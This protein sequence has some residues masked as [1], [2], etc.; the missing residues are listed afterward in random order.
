MKRPWLRLIVL[1]GACLL[2]SRAILHAMTAEDRALVDAANDRDNWRLHGRTYDNQRFSPLTQINKD[3]VGELTLIRTLHT[4]VNSSFEDTPIEVDGVL[5]IVTATNHVAAWDAV[6]GEQL[7]AWAP[8][9]L[10]YTEACCG[11]QARGVAVAYG[12]VYTALFDG[13]L[14]ALDAKTGKLV[15]ETDPAKTHPEPKQ[16]YTY[17]QA[18]QVYDGMV[19]VGTAGA[20][21]ETRGMVEAYDAQTGN[22]IWEFRTT[23]APGEP[24]G[25]TWHGDAWKF[26]GGSVWN[27]PAMD[28]K[29]GLL[30]L[31]T[32]NPNPDYRGETRPGDNA[33]TDS[34]LALHVKTGKL[35][36]WYQ[37]V[38]HD[39]WDYDA[40]A[41]VM[42]FSAKDG[43]GRSV[44][45][46][47]EAGKVGNVFI[48]D[49]LTG[50]LLHKSE[51]FVDQSTNMFTPPSREGTTLLP[52][53]SGGSLWQPP[54]FSPRTGY[55]Y[56]LGANIP[57]TFTAI[58]FKDSQPGGPWVGRH[59]GGVMK[60]ADGP[61]SGTLTAIDVGS[62]KIAWQYKS[63]QPMFGGVLA[64]ASD[65]VF[66]GEMN[67]DF[68]AFD[69]R[70]G[71]KLWSHHFDKGVCSPAITYRVHGVQYLAVGANGCRGGHVPLGAP[72]FSDD[73]AIFALK[74]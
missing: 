19:I 38:P 48:V 42:L 47:G 56:V 41:P 64:T 58:D 60:R 15:W 11:P 26:G 70:T 63:P 24:G 12:K 30:V 14:V 59:T 35:A 3:T 72:L 65:L 8:D 21:Y 31:S 52:G 25:D 46:A 45:A 27:T 74:S 39:L 7:W 69:A 67:G 51:P 62:G 23:A 10:D 20:E 50:K 13:H 53:V 54:A 29:N 37:E 17:T 44:P 36:W 4:G 34:I 73:L 22:K 2:A 5:Y 18:P 49:R 68:S 61:Q 28:P 6:S 57:M 66:A 40:S 1:A 55:F 71:S 9:K 32:G 16:Y 43:H 33:Y